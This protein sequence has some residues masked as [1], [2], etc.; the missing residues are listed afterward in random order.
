MQQVLLF[1]VL[2]SSTF[3]QHLNCSHMWAHFDK[4][5][6]LFWGGELPTG[7]IYVLCVHSNNWKM[8]P[9]KLKDKNN[10]NP[11][12]WAASRPGSFISSFTYL[13]FDY[14]GL[15]S[16]VPFSWCFPDLYLLKSFED[17]TAYWTESISDWTQ[18]QLLFTAG[19]NSACWKT[20]SCLCSSFE[21]ASVL[22]Q[23]HWKMAR[24]EVALYFINDCCSH[25]ANIQRPVLFILGLFLEARIVS[26]PFFV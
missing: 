15:T 1:S 10:K 16:C 13:W 18:C 3:W 4:S 2:V 24:W 5:V 23:R 20:F 17:P 9:F 19:A 26:F 8:L 22:V 7:N 12:V 25:L 6:F 11:C 21:E 14:N